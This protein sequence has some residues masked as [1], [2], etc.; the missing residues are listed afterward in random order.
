MTLR[1]TWGFCV[2][3]LTTTMDVG[4]S[5]PVAHAQQAG[6][7]GAGSINLGAKPTAA[8]AGA[9]TGAAPAPAPAPAVPAPAPPTSAPPV[10]APAPAAGGAGDGYTVRLKALERN[11][12]ELKEQVFR[13]KARLNQLKETVLGGVIGASRGVVKFKNE[14]GGSFRLVKAVVA[15]DGVQ[16]FNKTDDSGRMAEMK[17]FDIYNG[18]IQP[19]SHTLSVQV[20]Y[21]GH[22]FGVFSYLKGMRFT[23]TGSNTFAAG[24]GKAT[25]VT[26]T[27][28][29]KGGVTTKME[30][31][32]DLKF[33][34]NSMNPEGSAGAKK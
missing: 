20:A 7:A 11:V 29:E 19:G 15:M 2:L 33:V 21:Q 24:E 12:N 31:K 18:A 16:I 4:L 1:R 28:V 17:E 25:T 32:P 34:V 13:T 10:G 3:V 30:D 8:A 26:I 6:T 22:G 27:G 14:M 23:N 5:A 9:V